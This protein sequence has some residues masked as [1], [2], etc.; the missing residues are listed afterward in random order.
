MTIKIFLADDHAIIRQGIKALL[1][2]EADIEIVGETGDGLAV[3]G[4][5]ENILPDV[6][7][8]D[9]EM[10]GM[11]GLE[12]TYQIRQNF[13]KTY[14][15]ILSMHDKEA[16]VLEALRK[17]ASGYV[18][19]GS[20]VQDLIQ[21]IHYAVEGKRFLSQPLSERAIEAYMHKAQ[22]EDLDP[23][24]TLTPRERQIFH[25]VIEG[26]SNK[27]IAERLVVSTRT[28]ETHRAK[29]MRKLDLNNQVELI[30]YAIKNGIIPW[31]E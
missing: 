1:E 20:E 18:L 23:Y 15:V 8:L 5:V 31:D 30:R 22:G 25:L 14:V 11:K 13:K 4:L 3:L 12:V 17:G 2:R 28:I 7:I 29:M 27:E 24:E 10:P 21:A 6:V 9:L 19:K 16:Y 26:L